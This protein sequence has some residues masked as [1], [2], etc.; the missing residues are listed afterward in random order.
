MKY[1]KLIVLGFIVTVISTGQPLAAVAQG[2]QSETTMEQSFQ[3]ARQDFL[4]KDMKAAADEIRKGAAY[5]KSEADK[6]TGKGKEALMASY[7]ELERLSGELKKGVV[8]SPKK[9][10]LA[11]A[12]AYQALAQNSYVKS[13]EAW[14]RKEIK[15]AGQHLKAASEYL[16]RGLTWAGQKGEAGTAKV[17]KESKDLS[18]K[19]TEGAGWA[20]S[21][22]GKG[23][24]DM[25]D[26]IDTFGKRISSK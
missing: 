8:T 14:T 3:K 12:H 15:N 2:T 19:L 17:I 10:E 6:A 24:K 21:E 1:L 26:K 25:G 5:V 16:E 20:A 11:F 23:L 22:V 4:Q 9:M 13:T 18:R 7:Q